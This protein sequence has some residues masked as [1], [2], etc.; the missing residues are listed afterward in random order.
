MTDDVNHTFF[1]KVV[2]FQ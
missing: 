2:R 1:M